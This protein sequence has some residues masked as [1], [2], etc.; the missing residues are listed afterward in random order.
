MGKNEELFIVCMKELMKATDILQ[1]ERT[2]DLLK[3][4]VER[5]GHPVSMM[6]SYPNWILKPC[7]I[8]ASGTCD[9]C[10]KQLRKEPLSL[11][12]KHELASEVEMMILSRSAAF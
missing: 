7:V 1:N 8:L 2:V 3:E 4:F 11:K 12:E 6:R 10:G 9:V 5:Y